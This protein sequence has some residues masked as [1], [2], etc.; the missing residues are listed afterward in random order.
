MA[1]LQIEHELEQLSCTDRVL[2]LDE[3]R[4]VADGPPEEVL[5]DRG[6]LDGA[7]LGQPPFLD[8]VSTSIEMGVMGPVPKRLIGVPGILCES[9]SHL[10]LEVPG[11]SLRRNR[12]SGTLRLEGV[13]FRY[14]GDPSVIKDLDLDLTGSS[15]VALMGTNGAGKSTLGKLIAGLLRP[16]AGC[17][18]RDGECFY[19]FQRPGNM[20]FSG[21]VKAELDGVPGRGRLLAELGLEALSDR[22]PSLL[23]EGEKQR[24]GLALA[25]GSEADLLVLDEPFKA[26]DTPMLE[27]AFGLLGRKDKGAHLI[28]TNDP[29][30]AARCEEVVIMS[31]GRVMS[32]G[33]PDEVLCSVEVM[34]SLGWAV[35]A[36]CVISRRS[37]FKVTS[38]MGRIGKAL[39]VVGG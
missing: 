27:R 25:L 39:R 24:L 4:T 9:M 26:L 38:D 22:D 20:F 15:S 2:V 29:G 7:G 1:I 23:S 35:P 37:G 33:P 36:A 5:T 10:G 18:R 16:D 13:R 6:C 28:I 32:R 8:V 17:I 19:L 12:R 34:R 31:N 14:P 30:M 21:S 11:P 3:G